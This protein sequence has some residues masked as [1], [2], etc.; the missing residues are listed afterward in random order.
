MIVSMFDVRYRDWLAGCQLTLDTSKTAA[1]LLTQKLFTLG[2]VK[3]DLTFHWAMYVFSL[4]CLTRFL[5]ESGVVTTASFSMPIVTDFKKI[6]RSVV[7]GTCL[8]VKI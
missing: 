2:Y 4:E 1:A 3:D 6:S 8:P 7:I 5:V